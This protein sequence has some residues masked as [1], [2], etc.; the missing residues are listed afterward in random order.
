MRHMAK[1]AATIVVWRRFLTWTRGKK[2]TWTPWFRQF[3]VVDVRDTRNHYSPQQQIRQLLKGQ[4]E[5]YARAW[6]DQ[7]KNGYRP[8]GQSWKITREKRA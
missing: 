2:R 7:L 4:D 5:K 6:T 1:S 8:F 3:L